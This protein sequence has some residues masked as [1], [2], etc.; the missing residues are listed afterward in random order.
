L[1]V[2]KENLKVVIVDAVV[3]AFVI[4]LFVFHQPVLAIITLVLA[5]AGTVLYI[6]GSKR[7]AQQEES[8]AQLEAAKQTVSM[9][10]ISKKKMR[11]SEAGLP[12]AALE[13]VSKLARRQKLPILKVKVG[14]QIMNLICEPEI[15]D[16]VPEKK[17]VKAT[18]A[19]LYVT[20]VKGLHGN[21]GVKK[22]E[23]KKGFWK[24]TLE[25]AQEKAGAKQIK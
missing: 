23:E 19:G 12:A 17:E 7:L 21:K 9:F 13:S 22:P 2:L 14:P 16:S 3:L 5:I 4:L 8:K 11:L 18:V 24:R 15:F 10:I 20:S 1:N 25:K 6:V